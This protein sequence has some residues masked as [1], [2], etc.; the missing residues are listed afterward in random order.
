MSGEIKPLRNNT[1]GS[2]HSYKK[3]PE[4]DWQS[5]FAIYYIHNIGIPDIIVSNPIP[6]V[7]IRSQKNAIESVGQITSSR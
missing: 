6:M 4:S 5:F 2:S 3:D 1:M 7:P